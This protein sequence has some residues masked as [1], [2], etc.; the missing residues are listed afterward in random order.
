VAARPP[1]T[2]DEAE[3]A[4]R[5]RLLKKQIELMRRYARETG[6]RQH[7][8]WLLKEVIYRIWEQPQI[9][10]PRFDKYSLWFHWSPRA[11]ARL[12]GYAP[13]GRRPD[14][15]GLRFEHLIPRGILAEELLTQDPDD[16]AVFLDTHFEAV[17]I[18]TDDD[19]QLNQHGVRTRMPD[20][21]TLGEDPWV[22]Y[23][24]AGFRR[25]DFIVPC[26]AR[27][28]LVQSIPRRREA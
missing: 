4:R 22:R 27:P 28:D 24:R 20:G 13:G 5:L 15:K 6:E 7:A 9:P 23:E 25:K 12:E 26:E 3:R 1:R 10:S 2:L 18:T 14:I 19:A 16:L 11:R 17:V 21:W 8:R